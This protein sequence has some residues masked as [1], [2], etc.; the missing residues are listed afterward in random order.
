M[1]S[2]KDVVAYYKDNIEKC[3]E[4]EKY[5]WIA[6]KTFQD[7]WDLQSKDFA[8]MLEDSLSEAYNLL[9]GSM[10]YPKKMV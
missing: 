1:V 2:I 10:Y 9:Q 8:G 4:D 6:V 3:W 7:N 5:K